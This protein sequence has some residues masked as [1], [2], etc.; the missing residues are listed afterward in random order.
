[1]STASF[2]ALSEFARLPPLASIVVACDRVL[3]FVEDAD[4]R[5]MPLASEKFDISERTLPVH[6]THNTYTAVHTYIS[7]TF[8]ISERTL[9]VHTTHNTYT[10]VHT[11]IAEKLHISE[12][13]LPVHD[14]TYTAVNTCIAE[15]FDISERTLPVHDNTCSSHI[16]GGDASIYT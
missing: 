4:A 11:Y 14:N 1:L 16:Y 7:E 10:A 2:S 9:P 13:Q 6:T 12:R 8:D 5:E 3:M 15:N